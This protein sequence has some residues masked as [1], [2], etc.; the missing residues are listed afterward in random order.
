MNA[1]GRIYLTLYIRHFTFIAYAFG[2]C[3]VNS[4]YSKFEESPSGFN[5]KYLDLLYAGGSKNYQ[6]LLKNFGLNPKDKD[7]WQMGMNLIKNLIDD[8]EK[9]S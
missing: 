6:V 9:I 2:D 4:L 1:F 7:F 3:L 5:D 8:L